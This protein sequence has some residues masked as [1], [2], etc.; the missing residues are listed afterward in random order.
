METVSVRLKDIK[1][2][3][4]FGKLLKEKRSELVRDLV[5]EGRKMKALNLYKSK[6]VSLGLGARFAGLSLSEFLDLMSEHNINLNLTL[7]DAK[8]SMKYA[9]ELL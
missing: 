4:Y 8:L 3:D 2:I 5:E 9:K 1:E 7:E 6:K